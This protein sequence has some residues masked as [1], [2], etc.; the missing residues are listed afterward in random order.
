MN[1]GK[2]YLDQRNYDESLE[3]YQY[4]ISILTR[5]PFRTEQYLLDIYEIISEVYSKQK[6]IKI[7]WSVF[8]RLSE[9]AKAGSAEIASAL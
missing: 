4:A 5:L 3:I 6:N 7:L 8:K 2:A 1:I 9:F